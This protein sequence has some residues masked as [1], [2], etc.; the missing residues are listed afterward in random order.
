LD[1]LLSID[2]EQ[3]GAVQIDAFG[4]ESNLSGQLQIKNQPSLSG[5]GTL[6]IGD[7]EYRAYGQELLIRTGEIQFNGPLSQPLLY[8]EAIR[9]PDLTEDNVVAGIRIDGI[10]NQPNIEI[11]SEP[12]LDQAQALS[13][14]LSGRGEI[15]AGDSG[16]TNYAGLLFGLGVSSS[17]TLTNNV[18]KALGIEQLRLQTKGNGDDTQITV[19]GKLSDDF[20]LEY[21]VGVANSASEVRLRY[22][23]L[24]KLYLEAISGYYNSLLLYYRFS[25]GSVTPTAAQNEQ[26][27][28]ANA[29]E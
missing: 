11:F 15:S 7:G 17:E 3:L 2:P 9:D 14:L 27:Q 21:G 13:Y 5:F 16:N 20:T 10:A 1:V 26:V 29:I 4:L 22:Q 18:G 25:R 28:E 12:G 24:P 23:L 6:S 8:V 19:S